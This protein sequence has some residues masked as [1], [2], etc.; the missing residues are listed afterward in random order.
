M[1][2]TATIH[3]CNLVAVVAVVSSGG[4]VVLCVRY[5]RVPRVDGCSARILPPRRGSEDRQICG[6]WA[7]VGVLGGLILKLSDKVT[8]TRAFAARKKNRQVIR[9]FH[10][11]S[12][13]PFIFLKKQFTYNFKKTV[14]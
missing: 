8:L 6:F 4:R 3:G 13:I 14:D 12:P 9:F 1:C 7:R 11:V 2:T 10:R 5:P